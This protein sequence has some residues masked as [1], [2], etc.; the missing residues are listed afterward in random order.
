M[1]RVG[2]RDLADDLARLFDDAEHADPDTVTHGIHSY[3]GR[4]HPAIA[5]GLVRSLAPKR[6]A[7]LDPFMGS[8]TVVVEAMLAGHATVGLDLNPLA[9]RIAEVKTARRDAASIEAFAA[10]AAAVA[11][12]STARVQAR[13]DS[14]AR[15]PPPERRWY[16]PHVLKEL[17]GL[18]EEIR[19]VDDLADRRA[20]EVLF[21]AIVVK[22]S[23][24]R[25]DTAE[26]AVPKRIRKG[27]VTEFFLRRADELAERW[28]EVTETVPAGTPP[29]RLLEAP[30][31]TLPKHFRREKAG[32]VITSP[33]YG[34]T[35]DYVDH[36]ARRYPW[37]GIDTRRFA[38]QEI[39]ARRNLQEATGA[40]RW[41]AELGRALDAIVQV[42]DENGRVVLILGDAEVGGRRIP[43]VPHLR[44]LGPRHGLS[45]RAAASQARPDW[46]GGRARNESIVLFERI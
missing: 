41:D 22:F 7:V 6:G 33:P 35:F 44:E 3:P 10:R 29:P 2:D 23:R 16:E 17:A 27:L 28:G 31:H 4:L 11:E 32:L 20:L 5:R 34:G 13:A 8:G 14:R 39:G 30:V 43:A 37:L 9:L 42:L 36:H 1:I 46:R 18:L 45:L 26:R 40:D 19:A 38:R 15:I 24:Q 12:A 25:S 21:S